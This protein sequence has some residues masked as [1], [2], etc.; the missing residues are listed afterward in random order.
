M[1]RPQQVIVEQA[2]KVAAE[3][4]QPLARGALSQHA[5]STV[6]APGVARPWK[7]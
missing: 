1:N 2:R 6:M 5:F 7:L 4:P 3:L